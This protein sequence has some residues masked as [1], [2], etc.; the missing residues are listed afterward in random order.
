[1]A[2]QALEDGRALFLQD[3]ADVA[4]PIETVIELTR[5]GPGTDG[6]D[7]ALNGDALSNGKTSTWLGPIAWAA[8]QD[9]ESLLLKMWPAW[10]SGHLAPKVRVKLG[11]GRERGEGLAYSLKWEAAEHPSLFP[12]LDGDLEIAPLGRDRCR[13]I[14]AASYVPPLGALGRRL[15]RALL[16]RVAESTVRSFLQRLAT[17]LESAR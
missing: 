10:A 6:A 4:R 16:H 5:K 7:G 9:G 2:D 17:A 13:L 12:V 14:L 15:D 11:A 3:F 1:M 8:E